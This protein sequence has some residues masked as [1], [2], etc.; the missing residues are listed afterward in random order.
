MFKRFVLIFHLHITLQK[1]LQKLRLL[2]GARSMTA[3]ATISV[4]IQELQ[5]HLRH[6]YEVICPSH[7]IHP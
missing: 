1:D 7:C 5:P 2:H 4:R 6:P 3:K